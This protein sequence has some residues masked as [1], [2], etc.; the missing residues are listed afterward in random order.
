MPEKQ[1]YIIIT[2]RVQGVGFRHFAY[3]KA[4]EF[5]ISGWVKN[6]GNGSVELEISGL[7][8]DLDT[9]MGWMKIGPTRAIIR[10][11]SAS[12]LTPFRDFTQFT[13]R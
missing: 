10:D 5:N 13:I 3:Q 7:S 4:K 1:Y 9:F 2:G 8:R 6:T 11:F 12:E